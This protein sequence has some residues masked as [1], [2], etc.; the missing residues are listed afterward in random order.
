MCLNP[1][2]LLLVRR[3]SL[4]IFVV[5]RRV[6]WGFPIKSGDRCFMRGRETGNQSVV[7]FAR[8]PNHD[9]NTRERASVNLRCSVLMGSCL[10]G[11]LRVPPAL[12][13]T[14]NELESFVL[15]QMTDTSLFGNDRSLHFGASKVMVL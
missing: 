6:P 3:R 14:A 4:F 8:E 13:P 7:H 5:N 9:V 12:L 10:H 15:V 11:V 2:Y 1:V